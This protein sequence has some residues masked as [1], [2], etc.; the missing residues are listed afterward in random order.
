MSSC[1]YQPL[2][3]LT[4]VMKM[5]IKLVLKSVLPTSIKNKIKLLRWGE[6][7]NRHTR[8]KVLTE[9]TSSNNPIKV[10]FIISTLPMWRSQ[11][12]YELLLKDKR[13]DARLIIAPFLRFD[14]EDA[15]RYTDTISDYLNELGF[16]AYKVID[17]NFNLKQFLDD[18]NPSIIFPC[19]PYPVIYGNELDVINNKHRIYC[20][21]PYGLSITSDELFYN[22]DFLNLCWRIYEASNLN[23]TIAQSRMCNKAKNV[24]VVGEP[25]YDKFINSRIDPWKKVN[26]GHCRKKIIWAPHFSIDPNLTLHRASF[27]WLYEEML[28]IANEYRDKLQIAFKPHPNLHSVLCNTKGWGKKKTDEYYN[29]WSSL[30]N[31][32]LEEGGF[33]DLFSHSDA[34]IHDSG[35]FTGEY[36]FVNKPVMFT[37]Q[38][39]EAS[40]NELN[41]LGK[42]CM[43]LHYIGKTVDDIRSFID[44]IVL[45]GKD[46]LKQQRDFF[47][48]QYLVPPNCHS[49]AENIYND[50]LESLFIQ[51]K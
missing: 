22:T 6:I 44:E 50:L 40:C 5:A 27:L 51:N 24:R 20:Y 26:D 38:N 42:K 35:S 19:Q 10:L 13:F 30:E 36:L 48:H 1:N 15:K 28:N 3:K 33:V 49:V 41:A 37:T 4:L 18:F 11:G 31:T 45:N 46:N 9:I 16:F 23:L 14:Q 25:D 7:E 2:K 29:L 43:D 8:N 32:Q 47:Y 17:N 39:L 12:V 34:M 21:I